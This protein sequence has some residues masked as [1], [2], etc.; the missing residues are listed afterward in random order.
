MPRARMN[1]LAL[2]QAMN[3]RLSVIALWLLEFCHRF[4][5]SCGR[6]SLSH[7]TMDTSGMTI[8]LAR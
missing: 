1:R 5:S 4:C 8:T 3:A 7:I 2:G 6:Q